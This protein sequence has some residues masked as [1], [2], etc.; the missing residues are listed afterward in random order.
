MTRTL[1]SIWNM[2]MRAQYREAAYTAVRVL[3]K[4]DTT[5]PGSKPS[6]LKWRF[7]ADLCYTIGMCLDGISTIFS[8]AILD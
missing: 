8:L 4:V 2:Y 7:E 1:N 6:S 3:Q 5:W